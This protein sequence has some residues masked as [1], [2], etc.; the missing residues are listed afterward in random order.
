MR[1][2]SGFSYKRGQPRSLH[3]FP[4][5]TPLCPRGV[6]HFGAVSTDARRRRPLWPPR[7]RR[8]L[9]P[10]RAGP[11]CPGRSP[12]RRGMGFPSRSPGLTWA[13]STN[14]TR[15][16]RCRGGGLTPSS[17][18]ASVCGVMSPKSHRLFGS[19]LNGP[20]IIYTCSRDDVNANRPRLDLARH[21]SYLPRLAQNA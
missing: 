2:G 11:K 1:F 4:T 5:P 20:R 6:S 21:V 15:A 12:Q 16:G 18:A 13:V 9:W 19:R 7:R 17:T 10:P 8:P 3:P 14:S